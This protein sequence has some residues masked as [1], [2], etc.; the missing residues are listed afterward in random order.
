VD[1]VEGPAETGPARHAWHASPPVPF[2]PRG[3]AAG[4]GRKK[5]TTRRRCRKPRFPPPAVRV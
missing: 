3:P 4:V 5:P 2:P 1:A